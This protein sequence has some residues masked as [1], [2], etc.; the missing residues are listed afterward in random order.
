MGEQESKSLTAL[1]R[2]A[3]LTL[4]DVAEVLNYNRATIRERKNK[5]EHF[6]VQEMI[7]I[8]KLLK[9]TP[10]A[11]LKT[12]LRELN[13]EGTVVSENEEVATAFLQRKRKH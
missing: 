6:T 2:E 10:T 3:D 4:Q 12:I 13:E 1:I 7:V 8:A 11:I 5:P 9:K